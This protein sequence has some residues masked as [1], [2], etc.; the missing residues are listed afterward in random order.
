MTTYLMMNRDS[1][2]NLP[3]RGF[4]SP[5]A[6]SEGSLVDPALNSLFEMEDAI[7]QMP[8]TAKKTNKDKLRRAPSGRPRHYFIR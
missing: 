8:E 5:A 6:T 1:N 3:F 2:A 4:Q 7:A